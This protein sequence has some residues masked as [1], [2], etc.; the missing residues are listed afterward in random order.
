MTDQE[1]IERIIKLDANQK[2]MSEKID[3]LTKVIINGFKDLKDDLQKNYVKREAFLPVRAIA[4]GMVGAICL[5][6]IY[7]LYE[8]ITK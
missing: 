4:Y 5:A 1:Q 3:D 7:A 6:F 2:T 8:F